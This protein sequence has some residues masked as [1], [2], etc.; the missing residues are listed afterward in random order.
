[1]DPATAPR[2]PEHVWRDD[3]G[4]DIPPHGTGPHA[5]GGIVSFGEDQTTSPHVE[6]WTVVKETNDP[7]A[8]AVP[9][10]SRARAG[11]EGISKK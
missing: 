7:T 5:E 2:T 9:G 11:W 3:R 10:V 8:H 6:G 1:M 4:K